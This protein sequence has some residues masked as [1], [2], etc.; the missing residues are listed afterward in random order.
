MLTG[1]VLLLAIAG[2]G[3]GVHLAL[4]SEAPAGP[5]AAPAPTNNRS[6]PQPAGPAPIQAELPLPP[7]ATQPVAGH[8]AYPDGTWLPPLNGA[9]GVT[10]MLFHRSMP[11]TKVVG[12]VRD[13]QGREWYVHENG[14]RSTTYVDANGRSIADV[15]G[16]AP[17][18]PT[19]PEETV[20]PRR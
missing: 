14:F 7:V 20:P 10:Q 1:V 4:S 11:Y 13:A 16:P 19:L 15:Q 2:A 12:K 3:Y 17:K 18:Q 8:V 9:S 6:A 5:P